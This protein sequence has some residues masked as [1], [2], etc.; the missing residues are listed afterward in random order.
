MMMM[1]TV[2]TASCTFVNKYI[3]VLISDTNLEGIMPPRFIVLVA[4]HPAVSG[5]DSKE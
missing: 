3:H 5:S 1:T 2:L 4:V